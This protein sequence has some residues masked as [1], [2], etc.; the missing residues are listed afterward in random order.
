[1]TLKQTYREKLMLFLAILTFIG[2]LGY[3][4]SIRGSFEIQKEC[5]RLES[6]IKKTEA[7]I[8]QLPILQRI[9]QEGKKLENSE[10]NED[11][12]LQQNVLDVISSSIEENEIG[13]ASFDALH[14][15]EEN[16]YI[17]KTQGFTLKGDYKTSLRL[18]ERMESQ[19]DLS[20]IS[21]V[22]YYTEKNINS[23]KKELYAKVYLQKITRP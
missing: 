6:E 11:Q 3:Q 8:D 19:F 16:K 2:V 17:I 12:S 1:M 4:R 22:D 5:T 15:Y 14:S 7:L 9:Y 10:G 13:L 21:S 18:L 20:R 23:H